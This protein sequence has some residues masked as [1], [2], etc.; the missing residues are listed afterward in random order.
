M[1]EDSVP[2][3][4]CN[5]HVDCDDAER[6][7]GYRPRFT[8]RAPDDNRPLTPANFHC[9]DDDCEDCFGK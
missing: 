8:E 1:A 4:S 7:N 6:R 9:H 2:Q 5:R 3:R